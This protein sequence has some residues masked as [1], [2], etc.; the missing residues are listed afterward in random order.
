[1]PAQADV[2]LDDLES[3]CLL[4]GAGELA[5]DENEAPSSMLRRS[6]GGELNCWMLIEADEVSSS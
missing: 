2:D 4:W 1:M 6:L 5:T 3:G